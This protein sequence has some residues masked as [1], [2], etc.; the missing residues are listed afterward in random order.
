V[1]GLI[2]E[3]GVGV[4]GSGR[5]GPSS[6]SSPP[7]HPVSQSIE[8]AS[9][10][11]ATVDTPR[12]LNMDPPRWNA[13]AGLFILSQAAARRNRKVCGNSS[14]HEKRGHLEEMSP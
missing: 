4:V 3:G 14:G 6:P 12:R 1:H 9:A 7:P 2:D 5:C 8:H 13:L 10:V 11:N